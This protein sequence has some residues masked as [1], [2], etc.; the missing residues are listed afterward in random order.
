MRRFVVVTLLT[1]AVAAAVAVPAPAMASGSQVIRDC[2]Q[3]GDLDKRYSSRDLRDAEGELP[4]DVDEYTDCRDVINQAQVRGD[5]DGR[6]GGGG[7]SAGGGGSGGATSG[8]VPATPDDAKEIEEVSKSAKSDDAPTLAVG[9]ER[10]EPTGGGLL[11]TAQ[12]ANDLPLPLLLVLISVAALGA[13]GGY[14]AVRRRFPD[15]K[16]L[17]LRIIRR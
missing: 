12:A 17:A 10:I 2:A 11:S 5:R 13:G 7:G 4:T 8:S 16:A 6:D 9:D 15:A 1:I 3:D 14:M